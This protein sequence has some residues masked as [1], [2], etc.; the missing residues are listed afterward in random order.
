MPR[1]AY[2]SSI[3][4]PSSVWNLAGTLPEGG[5]HICHQRILP[6]MPDTVGERGGQ[7]ASPPPRM[8]RMGLLVIESLCMRQA[9]CSP[10]ICLSLEITCWG[11]CGE[12]WASLPS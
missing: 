6:S 1:P 4:L 8:T 5:R 11:G 12:E 10:F 2:G 7:R 3:W 9:V